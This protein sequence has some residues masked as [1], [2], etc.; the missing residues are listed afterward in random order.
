MNEHGLEVRY[1]LGL[2]VRGGGGGQ[3]QVNFKFL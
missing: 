1:R 2:V 3:Q